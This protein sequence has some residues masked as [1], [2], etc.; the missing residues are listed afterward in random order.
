MT[1][2]VSQGSADTSVVDKKK[3]G[4][5]ELETVDFDGPQ[6]TSSRKV[7]DRWF[8]SMEAPGWS[9]QPER[10]DDVAITGTLEV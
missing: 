10:R 9:C 6:Y 3:K 7:S 8:L 1:R 5:R 2:R 4:K